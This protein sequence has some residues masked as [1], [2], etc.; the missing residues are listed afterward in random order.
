MC[1]KSDIKEK[2]EW[3]LPPYESAS[4]EF[5]LAL[6]SAHK[7]NEIAQYIVYWDAICNYHKKKTLSRDKKDNNNPSTMHLSFLIFI[8]NSIT[9]RMEKGEREWRKN[10]NGGKE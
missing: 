9:R 3:N 1:T 8:G 2:W 10:K 5:W 7:R 4:A 6:D